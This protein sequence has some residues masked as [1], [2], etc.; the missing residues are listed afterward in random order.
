[1][2][3]VTAKPCKLYCKLPGIAWLG[4]YSEYIDVDLRVCKEAFFVKMT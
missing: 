4:N 3:A 1:M 2:V